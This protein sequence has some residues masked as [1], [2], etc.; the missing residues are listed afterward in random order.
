MIHRYLVLL[1]ALLNTLLS[2]LPAHYLIYYLIHHQ[3]LVKN[4]RGKNDSTA[5]INRQQYNA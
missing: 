4:H 3:I 1:G 5:K 2:T